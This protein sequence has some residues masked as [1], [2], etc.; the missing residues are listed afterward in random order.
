MGPPPADALPFVGE[1]RFPT[2][3]LEACLWLA[4]VPPL[5]IVTVRM[6]R[7]LA[8]RHA[9]IF[10]LAAASAGLVLRVLAPFG[11]HQWYFGMSNVEPGPGIYVNPGTFQPLPSRLIIFGLGWATAGISAFNLIAGTAAI[12]YLGYAAL[13]SGFRR[14][15]VQLFTVL[16]A[17][18]PLY[19]RYSALDAPHALI[20][21]LFA[22]ATAAYCRL[23]TGGGDHWEY[24]LLA[25]GIVLAS[26]IRIESMPLLVSMPFFLFHSGASLRLPWRD[27]PTMAVAV[28]GAV[29]AAWMLSVRWHEVSR[30]PGAYLLEFSIV[31]LISDLTLI[32]NPLPGSWIPMLLAVPVWIEVVRLYR[33]RAWSDLL[34]LY[35]PIFA[36]SVPFLWGAWHTD[37]MTQGYVILYEVFVLLA[38]AR[39]ADSLWGRAERGELL[40]DPVRRSAA[41]AVLIPLALLSVVPAYY[42]TQSFQDEF[43][44]LRDNLPE[45][46]ATV[47]VL[48]D[49]GREYADFACCLSQPYPVLMAERPLLKWVVIDQDDLPRATY[50]KAAFDYYYP[51]SLASLVPEGDR[52]DSALSSMVLRFALWLGDEAAQ[53]GVRNTSRRD[54]NLEELREL[55]HRIRQDFHLV[56][57]RSVAKRSP[58]S[59]DGG[60]PNDEMVLT[61]YRRA[62]DPASRQPPHH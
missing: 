22:A 20:V 46:P 27:R 15:T 62:N 1:I 21:L 59:T 49:K 31:T 6:L 61:I 3:W 54:A 13:R 40:A 32:K 11:P 44:F 60:F 56:P 17:V 50:R 52:G 28:A 47:L 4:I 8:A 7:D 23:E 26:P 34:S 58:I 51:G 30:V 24:T 43:R 19:V 18:T 37:P 33:A 48:A 12:V 41:V 29:G 16:L 57:F 39:C 36:C 10:F 9:L 42:N 2:N 25:L 35:A 14:R 53:L 55:D 5:A 38:C 45:G